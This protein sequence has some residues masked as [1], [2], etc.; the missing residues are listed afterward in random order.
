[1]EGMNANTKFPG[2][3]CMTDLKLPS[4]TCCRVL[5]ALTD[6]ISADLQRGGQPN[7][8]NPRNISKLHNTRR[9]ERFP[10]KAVSVPRC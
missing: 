3:S 8:L 2:E 5:D 4:L 7:R 6:L 1:M 9:S 10:A